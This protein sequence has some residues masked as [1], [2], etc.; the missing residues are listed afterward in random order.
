MMTLEEKLNLFNNIL[1][2]VDEAEFYECALSHCSYAR[3]MI[4]AWMADG[5]LEPKLWTELYE[6]AEAVMATKYTLKT[7]TKEGV[8][9]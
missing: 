1:K 4:G 2:L 7:I 8:P 6:K 3:G 9:F 5:T